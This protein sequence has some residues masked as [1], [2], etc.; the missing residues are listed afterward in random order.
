[1][2]NRK[3]KPGISP[4][5]VFD[6]EGLERRLLRR[7]NCHNQK[8]TVCVGAYVL[9]LW[10]ACGEYRRGESTYGPFIRMLIVTGQ[11][12]SEIASMRREEIDL[13]KLATRFWSS[14]IRAGAPTTSRYH[15]RQS[16]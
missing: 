14:V 13:E 16:V 10:Q 12:R 15:R 8:I 2:R 5:L 1:M 4:N 9:P 11:R 7:K 3:V 6:Q